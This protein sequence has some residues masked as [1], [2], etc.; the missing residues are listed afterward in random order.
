MTEGRMG[1]MEVGWVAQE[2]DASWEV[3]VMTCLEIAGGE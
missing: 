1:K 2:K 3:I